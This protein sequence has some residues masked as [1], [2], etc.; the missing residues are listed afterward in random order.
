[1]QRMTPQF[2]ILKYT[3]SEREREREKGRER[4]DMG[5]PPSG[6][7]GVIKKG[8]WTPEEDLMLASYIQE[9]GPGNWTSVPNSTGLKRC[10]KSCRLRWTNYLRPG[11]KRGNFTAEED[12]KIIQLQDVLGNKWASI[13]HYLPERTDNDIKNH[14]NTHLKKAA[15][16][17]RGSRSDDGQRHAA[18]SINTT[19]SV[20]DQDSDCSKGRWERRLQKNVHMAKKALSDALSPPASTPDPGVTLPLT[21]NGLGTPLAMATTPLLSSGF[22]SFRPPRG[23]DLNALHQQL[24]LPADNHQFRSQ[25]AARITQASNYSTTEPYVFNCENIAVWLQRWNKEAPKSRLDNEESALIKKKDNYDGSS[26]TG[27]LEYLS[28]FYERRYKNAAA[29]IHNNSKEIN[30]PQNNDQGMMNSTKY[31][32]RSSASKEDSMQHINAKDKISACHQPLLPAAVAAPAPPAHGGQHEDDSPHAVVAAPASLSG[33]DEDEP[34]PQLN[35]SIPYD[36]APW[37]FF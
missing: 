7:R 21:T 33:E 4:S 24:M 20:P 2:S 3:G 15:D 8:P 32:N 28:S 11:I 31:V 5:R 14:W 30:S 1:M 22:M 37:P 35:M 18:S 6:V 25:A 16:R 23:W 9:N 10:S 27:R 34:L 26:T 17:A 36:H 29:R 12:R 13:A 19:T